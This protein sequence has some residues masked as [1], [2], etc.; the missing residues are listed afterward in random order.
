VERRDS[1]RDQSEGV[2]DPR[3]YVLVSF[4]CSVSWLGLLRLTSS[5]FVYARRS[6]VDYGEQLVSRIM[7]YET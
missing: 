5:C 7:K 3:W 2:E 1:E 4:R 6:V